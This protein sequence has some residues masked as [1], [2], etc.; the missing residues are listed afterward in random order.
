[1]SALLAAA[2]VFASLLTMNQTA[3][4]EDQ[5]RQAERAFAKTMADRDHAAFARFVAEDAIF[6]GPDRALRGRADVA[7]GWKRFY[8]GA[9]A[10]FSW[11]PERV[12][13]IESGTLAIST[14]PRG[15]GPAH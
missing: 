1:M 4:L 5:V 12:L 15:T 2:W 6:L 3:A 7:A 13:V 10:P 11:E 14:G 9:T 8:E